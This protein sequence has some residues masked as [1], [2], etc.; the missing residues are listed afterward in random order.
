MLIFVQHR[1]R[2]ARSISHRELGTGSELS[3]RTSLRI[4]RD[5]TLVVVVL[6]VVV[7]VVV[8][9]AAPLSIFKRDDYRS[10]A[11]S[12]KSYFERNWIDDRDII[13]RHNYGYFMCAFS[14]CLSLSLLFAQFCLL[15]LQYSFLQRTFV[16]SKIIIIFITCLYIHMNVL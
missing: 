10:F 11:T 9:P 8:S 13:R 6:L 4:E 3:I 1:L 14:L 5:S 12:R 16:L 7:V 2:F 15:Q